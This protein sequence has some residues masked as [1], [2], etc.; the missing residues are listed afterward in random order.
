MIRADEVKKQYGS[1][2]AS[3]EK[4]KNAAADA[5][6]KRK[7]LSAAALAG[8]FRNSSAASEFAISDPALSA[9]L[10]K[11]QQ[12]VSEELKRELDTAEETPEI[13]KSLDARLKELKEAAEKDYDGNWIVRLRSESVGYTTYDSNVS[14]LSALSKIFPVFFFQCLLNIYRTPA[15]FIMIFII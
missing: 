3:V 13:I 8:L 4:L 10:L 15:E 5:V 1:A 6:E 9:S 2:A 7:S 14:K 12:L 11:T